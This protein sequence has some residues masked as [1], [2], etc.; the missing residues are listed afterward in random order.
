MGEGRRHSANRSIN[1]DSLEGG[2]ATMRSRAAS[3]VKDENGVSRRLSGNPDGTGGLS[4]SLRSRTS[5]TS[6]R[7]RHDADSEDSGLATTTGTIRRRPVPGHVSHRSR[8]S[9]EGLSDELSTSMRLRGEAERSTG[10]NSAVVPSAI[11]PLVQ[12]QQAGG[13][14]GHVR[15]ASGRGMPPSGPMAGKGRGTPIIKSPSTG[16]PDR[17]V[18]P[19][20]AVSNPMDLAMGGAASSAAALAARKGRL[21]ARTVSS[22]DSEDDTVPPASAMAMAGPKAAVRKAA[23]EASAAAAESSAVVQR[24]AAYI[25]QCKAFLDDDDEED[26]EDDEEEG[27]SRA[28]TRKA[29]PKDDLD[30]WLAAEGITADGKGTTPK[31][32]PPDASR[33][34]AAVQQARKSMADFLNADDSSDDDDDDG[35]PVTSYGLDAPSSAGP[36]KKVAAAAMP[37]AGGGDDD[38]DDEVADE[39]GDEEAQVYDWCAFDTTGGASTTPAPQPGSSQAVA[40][41]K[42]GVGSSPHT[43]MREAAFK[44]ESHSFLTSDDDEDDDDDDD[45]GGAAPAKRQPQKP[46]AAGGKAARAVADDDDDDDGSDEGGAEA[47]YDWCAFDTLGGGSKAVAPPTAAKPAPDKRMPPSPSSAPPSGAKPTAP[48]PLTTPVGGRPAALRGAPP[49]LSGTASPKAGA[50]AVIPPSGGV[51]VPP[52]PL[53][54]AVPVVGP[55]MSPYVNTAAKGP[56]VAAG[57]GGMTPMAGGPMLKQALANTAQASFKAVGGPRPPARPPA[58]R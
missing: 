40:A 10:I 29:Q 30:D 51:M 12:Q 34:A 56:P 35:G 32:T 55:G 36:A 24:N 54:T 47:V 23:P 39:E 58:L 44:S 49:H 27:G 46:A 50:G 28:A 20:A 18:G 45:D 7:S 4:D 11:S 16:P 21:L 5:S 8:A 15:Q 33:S 31:K 22:D 38:S 19:T 25:Q 3:L 57:G 41:S 13:R 26:G 1:W 2:T 14:G 6:P 17:R 42:A 37:S 53:S 52:S 43:S 48:Q 9:D